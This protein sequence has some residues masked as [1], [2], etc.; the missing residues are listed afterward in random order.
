MEFYPL[1]TR[2]KPKTNKIL[3]R[4]IKIQNPKKYHA[5]LLYRNLR[6]NKRGLQKSLNKSKK[7]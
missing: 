3:F 2:N 6:T 1:K 5:H 4:K 7:F